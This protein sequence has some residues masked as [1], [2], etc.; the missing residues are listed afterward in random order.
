MGYYLSFDGKS[1]IKRFPNAFCLTSALIRCRQCKDGFMANQNHYV[2]AYKARPESFQSFILPARYLS[3][4]WDT[5]SV[6]QQKASINCQIHATPSTCASCK[7]GHYLN[8]KKQCVANPANAIDNCQAYA[9]GA[10]CASCQQG[11]FLQSSTSC[12]PIVPVAHCASYKQ[13]TAFTV[14]G[15]CELL[16]YASAQGTCEARVASASLQNC[17]STAPDADKCLACDSGFL[18]SSDGLTCYKQLKSCQAHSYAQG[19]ATC[20]R[21]SQGYYLSGQDCRQGS[22][23][24]CEVYQVS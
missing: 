23:P 11:F 17:Q 9:T 21:C 1:C 24:S 7:A 5:H 4:T 13:S 10:Q 20:D 6:C 3:R 19:K 15:Q 12:K 8:S 16:Y 22:D 18:L 14:C 2:Q